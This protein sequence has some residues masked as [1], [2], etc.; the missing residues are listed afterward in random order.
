MNHYRSVIV[1]F[2]LLVGIP[3]YA[4]TLRAVIVSDVVIALP[5][6]NRCIM[7][8]DYHGENDKRDLEQLKIVLKA[9]VD[10]EESS[11]RPLYILTESTLDN[12]KWGK[13]QS[14]LRSL[15]TELCCLEADREQ[16]FQ[17]TSIENIEIRQ[18]FFTV[19]WILST[20]KPE[21]CKENRYL[22]YNHG[23][24]LWDPE[25][26]SF[27]DLL[28]DFYSHEQ[29]A[30]N[31][32]DR[33]LELCNDLRLEELIKLNYTI[34]IDQAKK[35][36]N[37][38]LEFLKTVGIEPSSSASM[39]TETASWSTDVKKKVKDNLIYCFS[40]FFDL[41]A[42]AR[43][44]TLYTQNVSLDIVLIAGS[45]HCWEIRPLLTNDLQG[46]E[47]YAVTNEAKHRSKAE[48]SPEEL[49]AILQEKTP[50]LETS[51]WGCTLF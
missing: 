21:A 42:F 27:N 36:F 28:T 33:L 34:A 5:K 18:F 8:H 38:Y 49:Y 15:K 44:F 4:P 10:R 1:K 48:V 7:L 6:D 26:I 17:Y 50:G 31:T 22:F 23:T 30:H 24:Q 39:N 9:L 11:N 47:V 20:N 37:E 12:I 16:E 32:C 51:S 19:L 40:Y 29:S 35:R 3:S 46:E 43:I 13:S 2:L 41:N 25:S 45:N 14:I